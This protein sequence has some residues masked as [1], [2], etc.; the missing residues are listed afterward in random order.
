MWREHLPPTP[1]VI[2]ADEP[3]SALDVSVQAQVLIFLRDLQSSLRLSLLFNSHDLNV[4][5]SLVHGVAVMYA[6]RIAEPADTDEIL[7]RPRLPY[8]EAPLSAVLTPGVWPI[9]TDT[10]AYTAIRRIP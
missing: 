8:S 4:V 6:R 1:K 3:V 7:D 2:I 5:A 9:R 10:C